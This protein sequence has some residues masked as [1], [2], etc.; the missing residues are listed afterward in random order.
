M[1]DALLME[2]NMP[3]MLLLLLFARVHRRSETL[4]GWRLRHAVA[5]PYLGVWGGMLPRNFK[6]MTIKTALVDAEIK[7]K[8]FQLTLVGP[9]WQLSWEGSWDGRGNPSP[10]N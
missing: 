4:R 2:R 10:P 7:H 8:P 6:F 1:R 3:V 9:S 5:H